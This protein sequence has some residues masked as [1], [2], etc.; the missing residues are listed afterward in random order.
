MNLDLCTIDWTAIGSI[1]TVIAMI[2]A[3][4]TIYISVK[5]NKDNQKFQT[6]LVDNIMIINDSIQPIVVADYSVKLTK[7]IFTEDDRHFIDEMAANDISNNNRLSVQLI[8]YDRNESAKKVLMILSNMR[9][10]YGEWVRDLSILNLYKT[11]YII[12]PDEL[13][14]IILTMANM[15]KEIA[16][17]YEKDIHFIINEKNNDLNKA[18]NLMNIFCYTISSYLNEQKKIFEDELCAFVKEEQKRIDSMI[19]HDLIR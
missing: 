14:R 7:G 2:I 6:L 8:K 12:F 16:P 1:A 13:R 10:K 17:K 11:N 9:Q 15:S 18:I 3:Y 5:Q 19:F 4:R